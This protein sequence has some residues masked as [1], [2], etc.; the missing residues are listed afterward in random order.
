MTDETLYVWASTVPILG[1]LA[2][3]LSP[4]RPRLAI[5]AARVVAVA[6][7]VGYVVLIAHALSRPGPPMPDLATLAGLAQLFSDP[8]AALIG[9]FH[10]LAL[11]LWT[12]AWEAEEARRRGVPAL[13]LLPS[14]ALTFL[15]GPAGLLLFLVLRAVLTRRDSIPT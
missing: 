1:W 9:W 12:G 10:F 3:A 15:A 6:I 11:D 13:A 14:L 7:S 5:A 2:L 8:R 4:L